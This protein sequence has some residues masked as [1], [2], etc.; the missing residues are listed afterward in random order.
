MGPTLGRPRSHAAALNDWRRAVQP[1]RLL[2]R[3]A[4]RSPTQNLA[5]SRMDSSTGLGCQPSS[6]LALLQ[7]TGASARINRKEPNDNCSS[8]PLTRALKLP[9]AAIVQDMA[10]GTD[11]SGAGTPAASAAMRTTSALLIIRSEIRYRSPALP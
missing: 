3:L 2:S 8:V 10:S 4:S 1:A 5:A 6:R 7:S 11:F 9:I